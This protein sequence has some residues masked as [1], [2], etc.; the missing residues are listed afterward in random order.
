MEEYSDEMN[1]MKAK[2]SST[3][4]HPKGLVKEEIDF[5]RDKTQLK[6]FGNTQIHFCVDLIEIK[7]MKSSHVTVCDL[8]IKSNF[9]H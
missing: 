5:A 4:P 9:C 6:L 3:K 1:L 2:Y 8:E 7:E